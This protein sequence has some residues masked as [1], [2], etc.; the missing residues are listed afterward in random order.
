V[1]ARALLED[2]T[3]RVTRDFPMLKGGLLANQL[4]GDDPLWEW[5]VLAT[6]HV[7]RITGNDERRIDECVEGF[8]VL[9]LDFLR[10]QARFVKT[11]HYA[12]STASESADLYSDAER[13]SEYLDGLA[14]TYAMW[15]NHARMLQ[16]YVTGFVP[17]VGSGGRVLEIGPGHGLFASVLLAQRADA[18]YAG[19]DVSPRS[20][21]YSAAAFAAAGI[22]ADRYELIVADASD[23]KG[24]IASGGQFAAAICCEVLEHVDDPGWLLRALG[25]RVEPGAPA[26]V[27][28]VANMEAEDHVYLFHDEDDIRSLLRDN[29]FAIETD[30]PLALASTQE[31]DP[32]P[33]NYSA[34]VRR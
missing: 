11:G 15:P 8:V 27:T 25:A 4:A 18:R 5:A 6:E 28:T 2:L 21:S 20:I 23:A 30:R 7:L 32:R 34:I 17:L 33:L 29:G 9:S 26:F 22:E 19:I 24:P 14:L 31:M 12:H 3:A 10:L 1:N 13:M 16:F